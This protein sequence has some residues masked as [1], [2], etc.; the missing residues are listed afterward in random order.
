MLCRVGQGAGSHTT[1]SINC[2]CTPTYLDAGKCILR[3]GNFPTSNSLLV[4]VVL[5]DQ[6]SICSMWGR[7]STEVGVGH[8]RGGG[9]AVQGWRWGSTGVGVGHVHV[10]LPHSTHRPSLSALALQC[11]GRDR[12]P[13]QHSGPAPS[14][15]WG[16]GRRGPQIDPLEGGKGSDLHLYTHTLPFIYHTHTRNHTTCNRR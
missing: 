3:V 8:Y 9:G 14:T 6:L 15:G 2:H 7:G 13:G 1:S 4:W 5:E 10:P 12:G 16:P 11:G